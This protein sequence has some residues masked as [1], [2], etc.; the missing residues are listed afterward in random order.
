MKHASIVFAMALIASLALP[1][2]AEEAKKP[3]TDKEKISYSLGV[4][5]G[6]NLKTQDVDVDLA[7]LAQGIKDGLAG[8]GTLLT[9]EEIHATMM[10]FQQSVMQHQRAKMEAAAAKNKTEGDAFLAANK[11]KPGVK[12]LPDGLQYKVLKEGDGPVPKATDT[13][14]VNYRG[15][16]IDGKEFDS[17]YK[18]NE[19]TTLPVGRVIKG[20]SEALQMMKVGSKW[21]LVIP[22]ELGYGTHGA[23][24]AIPPNAT[25]VFEVELLGIKV[26][27]E[28][29]APAKQ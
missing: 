9:D 18:R 28:E 21:E 16:L 11:A 4:E 26:P 20:W 17:S 2:M 27:E 7:T 23:G 10:T 6:K 19:P 3:T 1:V 5:L 22:P 24:Q 15:T 8:E 13:V 29:K 14:I 12:T 25:L